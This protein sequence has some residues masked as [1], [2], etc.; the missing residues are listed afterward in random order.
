M[1]SA[2]QLAFV[3]ALLA[4]LLAVANGQTDVT[5]EYE[6]NWED[7]TLVQQGDR[8]KGTYACCGGGTIEGRIVEGRVLRYRWSQP[9]AEGHGVWRIAGTRLEGTWGFAASATDGG[10]WD[11]QRPTAQVAN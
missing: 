10:R 1:P 2:A 4:P 7:V 5:G 11:L 6:S 3:A 8:V 9:G